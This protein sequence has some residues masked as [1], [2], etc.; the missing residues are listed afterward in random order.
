[1][2][3][4]SHFIGL[5]G[6]TRRKPRLFQLFLLLGILA[7]TVLGLGCFAVIRPARFDNLQIRGTPRFKTQVLGA[8]ALLRAK[9]PDAY[10]TLTNNVGAIKQSKHSGMA[11]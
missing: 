10:E 1:M 4:S 7:L 3:D 5:A 11:A 8:L 9:A 2:A 6:I